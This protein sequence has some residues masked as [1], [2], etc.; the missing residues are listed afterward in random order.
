MA[1]QIEQLQGQLQ[2][3]QNELQKAQQEVRK[4]NQSKLQ[5]EQQEL[6]MKYK[7]EWYKANT[8]RTYKIATAEE[9]KRRTNAEIQQMYD[10]NPYN[11]KVRNV[12]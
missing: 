8:D 1:Q 7:L 10:G 11:D 4:L 5:L 6:D 9:Q 3:S 2:E 12:D